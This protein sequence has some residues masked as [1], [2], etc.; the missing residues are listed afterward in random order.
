MSSFENISY[1]QAVN[2][3]RRHANA[4]VTLVTPSVPGVSV[5]LGGR[6]YV[7]EADEH[8]AFAV[9]ASEQLSASVLLFRHC[10]FQIPESDGEVDAL[11]CAMP[12]SESE[13]EALLWMLRFE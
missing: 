13:G 10:M 6:L 1:D 12:G 3:V 8:F 11:V 5:Q 2:L 4:E 9:A 7:Q